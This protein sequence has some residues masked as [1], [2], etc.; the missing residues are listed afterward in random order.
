MDIETINV[1][2]NNHKIGIHT[3]IRKNCKFSLT[4]SRGGGVIKIF[5]A[6]LGWRGKK[7][8][9]NLSPDRALIGKIKHPRGE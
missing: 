9:R 2:V 7:A 1:T 3:Q 5:F 6:D 8:E 4:I